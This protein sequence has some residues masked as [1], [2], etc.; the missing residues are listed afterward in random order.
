MRFAPET[1]RWKCRPRNMHDW[2]GKSAMRQPQPALATAPNWSFCTG[3]TASRFLDQ[4]GAKCLSK[5]G[6]WCV[7]FHENVSHCCSACVLPQGI[8]IHCAFATSRIQQTTS[9]QHLQDNDA[10]NQT[11]VTLLTQSVLQL[12]VSKQIVITA[13]VIPGSVLGPETSPKHIFF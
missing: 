9:K 8:N 5:L 4:E 6:H 12:N 11:V 7:Q 3:S 1:F 2:H 10:K 13:V